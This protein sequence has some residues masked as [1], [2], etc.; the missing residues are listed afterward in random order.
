MN[1]VQ[2]CGSNTGNE[3]LVEYGFIME[4][5]D[6]HIE[7]YV[8]EKE[9]HIGRDALKGSTG[10]WL[11]FLQKKRIA[12]NHDGITID[13][14]WKV[15]EK[16]IILEHI[17]LAGI[18][19]LL[20]RPGIDIVFWMRRYKT[21]DVN[22]TNPIFIDFAFGSSPS[23]T[24]EIAKITDFLCWNIKPN[25]FVLDYLNKEI[26]K[27]SAV[28]LFAKN[29]LQFATSI[30]KAL[31]KKKTIG[32]DM[33]C[34][35]NVTVHNFELSS[36]QRLYQ[37]LSRSNFINGEPKP[38]VQG[39]VTA[40]TTISEDRMCSHNCGMTTNI[41]LD[42]TIPENSGMNHAPHSRNSGMNHAPLIRLKPA[43]VMIGKKLQPHMVL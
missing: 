6:N 31:S 43:L 32:E 11:N 27:P 29:C 19:D 1:F 4:K 16:A 36:F 35:F 22:T 24:T 10:F 41:R 30:R 23:C 33:N 8:C 12:I 38:H 7:Y 42:V 14:C 5:D 25:R 28:T 3:T 21:Y 40:S 37:I 2:I 20:Y 34:G 17:L 15:I 39:R 26:P 18:D 13:G 9:T